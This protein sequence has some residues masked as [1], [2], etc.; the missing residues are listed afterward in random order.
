[1]LNFC[2]ER[3]VKDLCLTRR[4][5]NLAGLFEKV[6]RDGLVGRTS[7]FSLIMLLGK[8]GSWRLHKKNGML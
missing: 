6:T 2:G 8:I 5:Q 3:N 1:M 7:V 4:P